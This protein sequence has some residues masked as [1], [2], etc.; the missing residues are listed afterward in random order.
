MLVHK[1]SCWWTGICL[2]DGFKAT[3]TNWGPLWLWN[4]LLPLYNWSIFFPFILVPTNSKAT[5]DL[6]CDYLVQLICFIDIFFPLD[7]SGEVSIFIRAYRFVF[8]WWYIFESCLF[9]LFVDVFDIFLTGWFSL[10][11]LFWQIRILII[12]MS[13]FIQ[14]LDSIVIHIV[15]KINFFGVLLNVTVLD[16]LSWLCTLP[17]SRSGCDFVRIDPLFRSSEGTMFMADKGSY[18]LARLISL[19]LYLFTWFVHIL[20]CARLMQ[21]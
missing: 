12:E 18:R 11:L 21:I 17:L 4:R 9:K 13:R 5:L 20:S 16:V 10:Y 8:G 15:V 7:D 14:R 6:V 3:I 2:S 1:F 19:S